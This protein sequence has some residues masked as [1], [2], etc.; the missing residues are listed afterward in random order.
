[1]CRCRAGLVFSEGDVINLYSYRH[2][3]LHCN[4]WR[5]VHAL[6]KGKNK[7]TSFH[8]TTCFCYTCFPCLFAP[9]SLWAA[10]TQHNVAAGSLCYLTRVLAQCFSMMSLSHERLFSLMS[11]Y[12]YSEIDCTMKARGC[13]HLNKLKEKVCH[14][15]EGYH[16]SEK[17]WWGRGNTCHADFGT[18]ARSKLIPS[19][20]ER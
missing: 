16:T 2:Q 4:P 13:E 11:H 18:H 12:V 15:V 3:C 20:F 9:T 7:N 8:P 19:G 1:M 14:G 10:H 6:L 17:K 5:F